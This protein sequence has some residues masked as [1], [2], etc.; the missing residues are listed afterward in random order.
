MESIIEK[1]RDK[2]IDTEKYYC[3]KCG[4]LG[5]SDLRTCCECTNEVD[6]PQTKETDEGECDVC[7]QGTM[8]AMCPKCGTYCGQDD[9]EAFAMIDAYRGSFT[10]ADGYLR[11]L[12]EL[13][14]LLKSCVWGPGK[15]GVR[16]TG[17]GKFTQMAID[18]GRPFCPYC[19]MAIKEAK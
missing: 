4:Y 13:L 11:A 19:G 18:K 3:S 1:L 8:T 2:W 5:A 9:D 14:A 7:K 15:H 12:D 17:C 10:E 16:K 6:G